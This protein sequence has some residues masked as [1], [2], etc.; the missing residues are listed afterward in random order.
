MIATLAIQAEAW[1]QEELAAQ[2]SLGAALAAVG[3]A[4][5]SGAG[6]ELERSAAALQE[7]LAPSAARETRR[8]QLF[9]RLAAAL[10]V[11]VRTL[12]LTRLLPYLSAEDLDT[13]R[14]VALRDELRAAVRANQEASRALSALAHYHRGLLEEIW[15]LLASGASGAEG[16]LVDARG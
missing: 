9:E 6:P 1:L 7:L 11:P 13:A 12:T 14:L 8:V 15:S 10:A 5:R 3:R 16:H 4:A 2:Q